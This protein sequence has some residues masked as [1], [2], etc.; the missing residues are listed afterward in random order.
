MGL[1]QGIASRNDEMIP[2]LIRVSTEAVY[3]KDNPYARKPEYATVEAITREDCQ[4]LQAQV[5]QPNRMVLAVYG[6]FKTRRDEEA[7]HRE[8]R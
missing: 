2:L 4:K 1:R 8:V 3:G 7:A 6:D 5:F